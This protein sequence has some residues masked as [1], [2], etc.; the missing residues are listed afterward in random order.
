MIR[1]RKKSLL[2]SLVGIAVVTA[3]ALG[4][5]TWLAVPEP[6]TSIA[7]TADEIYQEEVAE[8][9]RTCGVYGKPQEDRIS[10]IDGTIPLEDCIQVNRECR[11]R[12]GDHAVWSG[13]ARSVFDEEGNEELIPNCSCD[14]GF[15]YLN[16]DST[17]G[18][19][20]DDGSV[21]SIIDGPG[22]CVA[23]Q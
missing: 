19:T 15:E 2:L 13:T 10:E 6:P 4:A 9:I 17:V 1:N 8:A 12:L 16:T 11:A 14:S 3:T 20:M 21:F 7:P 5:K 18:I 23:R 22:R